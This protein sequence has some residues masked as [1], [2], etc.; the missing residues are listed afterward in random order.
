[1]LNNESLVKRKYSKS[2]LDVN[3]VRL[4]LWIIWKISHLFVILQ[5]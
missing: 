3:L 1:V 4:F 5:P 2:G